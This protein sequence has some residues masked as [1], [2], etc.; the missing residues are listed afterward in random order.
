MYEELITVDWFTVVATLVN[1]LI[2]FLVLKH[3]LYQ[4]VKKMLKAREDEVRG[5][6]EAAEQAKSE[7]DRLKAEYDEQMSTAKEQAGELLRSAARKAQGH[8]DEILSEAQQKAEER[9][10]RAERQ[11]EV[12]KRKAV[13]EARDQIADLALTAAEQIVLEELDSAKNEKLVNDFLDNLR[14]SEDT[15]DLSEKKKK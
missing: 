10:R 4:P 9:M 14:L 12:E 1:T 15:P 7:A 13:N 6:Y 2:L 3:F 11:I 5:T 8:A